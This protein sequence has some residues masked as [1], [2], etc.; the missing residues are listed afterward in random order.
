MA[1]ESKDGGPQGFEE[2][3]SVKLF[4]GPLFNHSDAKLCHCRQICTKLKQYA[5]REKREKKRSCL[6]EVSFAKCSKYK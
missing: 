4:V 1:E 6:T 2:G 5:F 3:N